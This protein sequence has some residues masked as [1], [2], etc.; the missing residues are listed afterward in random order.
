[1]S[2]ELNFSLDDKTFRNFLNGHPVVRHSHHYL[3]LITKLV[4][5]LSDIGGPRIL[6]EVVE[7]SIRTVL[8]D[9]F[10]QQGTLSEDERMR[11]GE[12][13][14]ATFGLG[15]MAASG[16]RTG[17]EVRLQRSHLDEGWR[18][19]WGERDRPVNYLACG[20]AAAL[21]GAAFGLPARSFAVTEQ[22]GMVMGVPES[23]FIVRAA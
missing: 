7:D 13:Y 4:E 23:R 19:K 14:F 16:D 10:Q 18:M 1:M 15:K 2:L 21:F 12:A 6:A 8:D 20:F 22:E 11:I 17:G 3:C 9:Y 5:D